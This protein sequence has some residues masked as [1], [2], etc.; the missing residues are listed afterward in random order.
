MIGMVATIAIGPEEDH[1]R[2]IVYVEGQ[3]VK[4]YES[5][6]RKRA[7]EYVARN[8]PAA[9]ARRDYSIQEPPTGASIRWRTA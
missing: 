7:R 8:F 1:L 2:L 9:Y 5:H 4:G 3:R 6:S